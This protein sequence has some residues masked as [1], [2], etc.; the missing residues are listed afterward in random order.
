MGRP[1]NLTGF[2]RC[3]ILLFIG[4]RSATEI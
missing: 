4:L 3:H 1:Y 2:S